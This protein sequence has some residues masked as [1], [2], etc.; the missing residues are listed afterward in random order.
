[1]GSY[2]GPEV[3]DGARLILARF[4]RRKANA[5]I[6]INVYAFIE[7]GGVVQEYRIVIVRLSSD[8][9]PPPAI[10]KRVRQCP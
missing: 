2:R 3:N 7:T 8:S 6:K 5:A 1:M 4:N 10:N 9:L